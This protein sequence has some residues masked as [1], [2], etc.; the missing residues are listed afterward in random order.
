[1]LEVLTAA[2]SRNLTSLERVKAEL[3]I[4]DDTLD[5]FLTEEIPVAS[6]AVLN[7]LGWFAISERVRET[8]PGHGTNRLMLSRTPV[9]NVESVLHHGSAIT[10]YVLEDAKAG[11]LFRARGW[12]WTVGTGWG[13]GGV[14][15]VARSEEPQFAVTY[16]GGWTVPDVDASTFTLERDIEKAVIKTIAAALKGGADDVAEALAGAESIRIG[17][18]QANFPSASSRAADAA[19][20]RP[21]SVPTH[22][23]ALLEPYRR[24]V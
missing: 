3:E 2:A 24:A 19:A 14:Y 5:A 23:L 21:V 13:L 7:V 6:A 18:L 4:T 15:P 10:D 8:L 9:T 1:M 16:T 17:P 22:A 20:G 11:F 12:E